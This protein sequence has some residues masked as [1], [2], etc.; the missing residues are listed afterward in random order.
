MHSSRFQQKFLYCIKIYSNWM[1]YFITGQFVFFMFSFYQA[2]IIVS[3]PVEKLL[4]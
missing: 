3:M 4:F 2:L 1:Y